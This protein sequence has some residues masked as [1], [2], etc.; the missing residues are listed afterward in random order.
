MNFNLKN[1]KQ[2]EPQFF[3]LRFFDPVFPQIN[4]VACLVFTVIPN[5]NLS[6]GYSSIQLSVKCDIKENFFVRVSSPFQTITIKS[7]GNG[8]SFKIPNFHSTVSFDYFDVQ[9][10]DEKELIKEN[11]EQHILKTLA[12]YRPVESTK[13]LI[14]EL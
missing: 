7:M 5:S 10:L 9:K 4:Y 14:N 6:V 3:K 12:K 8:K 2:Q 1:L 13:V 11:D